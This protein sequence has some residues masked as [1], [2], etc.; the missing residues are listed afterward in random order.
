MSTATQSATAFWITAPGRGELRQESLPPAGAD[1]VRVETLFSG[2]SRGT[3]ALV[4]NGLVPESERERMRAPFQSGDFSG[5]VK[6]G[7]SSVGRV[8]MGPGPLQGQI[9]FCLYPHQ[10]RYLVP[11]A[12]V[13]PLPPRLDPERAVL[14]ANMET[15]LNACWDAGIMPGDRVTVI[16][17]GVVGAAVA[18]LAGGIP[19]TRTT[20][21]DIEPKRAQLAEA[22]GL[23]FATPEQAEGD[24]D[25]VI[26]ASAS[27]AGLALALDIAGF[28]ARVVEMSWF[29]SDRPRLALGQAFHSRRLSLLAS[30][31]GH[32]PAGHRARWTH[33]RRLGKA[34]ELLLDPRLDAL[35]SGQSDFEELPEVMPALARG[36]GEVLCHRIRYRNPTAS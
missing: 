30:Q 6:Y 22:L 32:L 36:G 14:A 26:H 31:V 27:E 29:G 7:Y 16:G 11:A 5:P 23:A 17:A 2:V 34:L 19:G 33:R 35:I 20:L 9:V 13:L 4:F 25:V 12:A 21:V 15:A 10:D 1:R 3:E 18:W 28:E 24:Q 8:T